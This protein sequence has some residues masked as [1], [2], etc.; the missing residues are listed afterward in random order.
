MNVFAELFGSVSC[1]EDLDNDDIVQV[2]S[3]NRGFYSN[4]KIFYEGC[5]IC[6]A[7]WIQEG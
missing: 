3:C 7:E 1:I 4:E 6:R 2:L 5:L